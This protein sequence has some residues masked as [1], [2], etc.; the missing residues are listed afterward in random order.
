MKS[1]QLPMVLTEEDIKS[2]FLKERHEITIKK[3]HPKPSVGI[4]TGLWANALGKGGIIPIETLFYPS[5]NP[6]DFK[7][8]GA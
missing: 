7:L 6:L 1:I 4:V 3:I 5:T 8:T 2:K